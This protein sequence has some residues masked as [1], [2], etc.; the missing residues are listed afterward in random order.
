MAS[1]LAL[2]QLPT[3]LSNHLQSFA[4]ENKQ[5]TKPNLPNFPK[6]I[7]LL[8][9]K[10]H[11]SSQLSSLRGMP[12]PLRSLS[13]TAMS[14]DSSEEVDNENGAPMAMTD[15]TH[16]IEFNRVNC[17]VWVLHEAA[18]SFSLD[19]ESLG[20]EESRVALSMAW[21]GEDVH[22][23]HKRMAHRV[24]VY[25][26]FKTAIEMECLL[27]E[28]RHTVP[29]PSKEIMDTR[30][31]VLGEYIESQLKR[32]NPEL[33]VWFREVELSRVAG[34]FIPLLKT[35]T[36]EYAGSGVAGI[37]VAISC[38]A[39][40]EKLGSYRIS[41]PS[42]TFSSE[43]ILLNLMDLSKSLVTVEKLHQLAK[44][45]GFEHNF[46]SHFGKKVLPSDDTEEIE[47]WIGLAHKKLSAA[48][49]EECMIR[50]TDMSNKKAKSDLLATLGLFAYLGRQTRMF[51]SRMG[52]EDLD[53]LVKDFLGYLECGSLFIYPEL[54]SV[55]AYQT[56]IEIVTDEIGWLD[57]YAGYLC[58][59]NQ[60][61]RG[62][63]KL[64]AIQ[65]ETEIILSTAYTV[66]YDVFSGFAHFSRSSQQPLDAELL[67]FLVRSQSLLTVC[68]E[69]YWA[70]YDRPGEMLKNA[71]AG[72]TELVPSTRTIGE[73][74]MTIDLIPPES[75]MNSRQGSKP[76][77]ASGSLETDV[78][79]FVDV[80]R[81]AKP[82]AIDESLLQ[83]Y[84]AK[85]ISTSSDVWMGTQLLCIDIMVSMELLVKKMKG[86]RIT[87]RQQKK[88]KRTLND[89]ASLI[90]I[91]ILMLIPVSAVGHA[92]MLAAIK[93]YVPSMI[94]SPY[95]AD[96]LDVVKQLKRTKK[97]DVHSSSTLDDPSSKSS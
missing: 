44:M 69:D 46:L 88:L 63:K 32:R 51:L 84:S 8:S 65:A 93:K 24:A 66:C 7:S 80:T 14:A 95:S 68:L 2:Q 9:H 92:A 10:C 57:F 70:A 5:N 52:I 77:K 23:W 91:S 25:A 55:S 27:S 45:A 1:H 37:I 82:M 34:F 50:G 35:W 60:E 22:R 81:T 26:L 72:T 73:Q 43:D 56:F 29:C 78:V 31:N 36:V 47:F 87:I 13:A 94:P 89:V 30:T 38:C 76:R 15:D 42:F 19:V 85:L 58:F 90:P 48:F 59:K 83:K 53:E 86:Q 74:Q 97:M 96:R 21:N 54:S 4:S 17:L 49:Y 6:G 61:R 41:C 67:A 79:P 64:H 33:V 3:R 18:R 11:S 16:E 75:I 71:E 40:V 62:S 20:L 12:M 39:A 28:N